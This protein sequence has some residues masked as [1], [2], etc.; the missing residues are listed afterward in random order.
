MQIYFNM[1]KKIKKDE[2]IKITLLHLQKHSLNEIYAGMHWRKR[3]GIKD[4]Y[5]YLVNLQTNYKHGLTPCKVLYRFTYLKNILD[6]SNTVFMAKMVEDVLF[7][8]DKPNV[9]TRTC[10][11]SHKGEVEKLEIFIKY[12]KNEF[13]KYN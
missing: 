9:V 12:L 10:Y 3:K 11:E 1:E 8:N 6:C 5:T 2:T 13:R 4:K 7:P